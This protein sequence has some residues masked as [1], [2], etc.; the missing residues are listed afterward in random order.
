MSTAPNPWSDAVQSWYDEVHDFEHGYGAIW[1]DA[2]VGHYTQVV[3]YRSWKVGCGFARCP[4]KRYENYYVCQYSPAGNR[5]DLLNTPYAAGTPC[6]DCPKH[7][8]NGLCKMGLFI[9]LLCLPTVLQLLPGY[10]HTA[11]S[12]SI[13][14]QRIIVDKHNALRRGV[15]PSASNMLKM[16]WNAKAAE[17]AK[18]WALKCIQEHSPKAERMVDGRQCGENLYMSTAATRWD[19]V[20][21]ALYNEEKDFKYGVG[22]TS[23]NAVI[24]HYTQVVWYRSYQ[25]GCYEARCSSAPFPFYY[26][27]QYCPAGN[28][29][30]LIP[31]PYKSGPPCG[32]CPY[33]CDNGLCTNPCKH[34]DKYSNCGSLARQPGCSHGNMMEDC[35]ASCLCKTEIK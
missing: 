11:E 5:K 25:V 35:A 3:W 21:Q 16:E 19:V 8:D 32:D 7:C 6:G 13:E 14:D 30:H 4:N 26:V 33:A 1:Q 18:K 15:R 24:G 9:V 34:D 31:T 28:I 29:E 23:P 17:N 20:I 2:V 12:T 27:C 22:K 10:M